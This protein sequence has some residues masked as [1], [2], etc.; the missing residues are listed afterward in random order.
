MAAY[1]HALYPAA[2][3]VAFHYRGYGPSSGRPSAA[4]LLADAPLIH[5]FVTSR[6]RAAKVVVVGFSIGSAVAVRLAR[7]RPVQGVVLVTPFDTLERLAR[8]HYGWVPVKLLLRH[9]MAPVD[10]IRSVTAPVALISAERDF[11]IPQQ[12]SEPLRAA[13]RSLIMDKTIA[14]AGHN[15]IYSKSE[16]EQTMRLAMHLMQQRAKSS[17]PDPSAATQA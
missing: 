1:L 4:A 10:E 13:A 12:R 5:D 7:E 9:H 17:E 2:E 16:F 3:V 6:L 15:D 11:I 14:A 8:Q